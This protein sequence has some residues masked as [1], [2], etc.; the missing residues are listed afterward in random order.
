MSQGKEA[1][2]VYGCRKRCHLQKKQVEDHEET[3]AAPQAG[4]RQSEVL[5]IQAHPPNEE[6]QIGESRIF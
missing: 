2:P 1:G 4:N 6:N 3:N 5:E